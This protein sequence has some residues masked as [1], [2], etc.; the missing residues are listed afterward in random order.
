MLVFSGLFLM[1]NMLETTKK[2]IVIGGGV[3]GLAAAD[4]LIENKLTDVLVI[5]AQNR[6][7]GRI[8]TVSYGKNLCL[9]PQPV[10]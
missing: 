9:S 2:V 7:G 4:R 10:S 1:V 3:S 5:E 8:N 6:T